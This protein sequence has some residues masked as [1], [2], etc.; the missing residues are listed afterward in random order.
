MEL[1]DK[2]CF[3]FFLQHNNI[4]QDLN[5]SYNNI[6]DAGATYLAEALTYNDYLKILDLSWNMIRPQGAVNLFRA[7]QVTSRYTSSKTES[8]TPSSAYKIAYYLT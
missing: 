5:L 2:K 1:A 7:V 6:G 4:L 8:P 3:A